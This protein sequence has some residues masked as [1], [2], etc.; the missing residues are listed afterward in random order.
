MCTALKRI[1]LVGTSLFAT[2]WF[3]CP[4]AP[5]AGV[6]LRWIPLALCAAA[7]DH[8]HVLV[9]IP[10]RP[11]TVENVLLFSPPHRVGHGDLGR[12]RC[13]SQAAQLEGGDAGSEQAQL[14]PQ[15]HPSPL[16][17]MLPHVEWCWTPPLKTRCVGGHFHFY[18]PISSGSHIY[19]PVCQFILPSVHIYRD[20]SRIIFSKYCLWLSLGSE[21]CGIFHVFFCQ[22]WV[23]SLTYDKRESFL[24]KIKIAVSKMERPMERWTDI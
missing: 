18:E 21:N 6:Y 23:T 8:L 14:T 16:L 17:H 24:Q 5:C 10:S 9:L 7:R 2:P 13:S 11:T 20:K 1:S 4:N 15:P 22:L 12:W 3:Q 19:L